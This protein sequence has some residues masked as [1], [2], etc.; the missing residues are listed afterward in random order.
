[1][2]PPQL[3]NAIIYCSILSLLSLGLSLTYSITKVP[4]FAQASFAI[5]G[6][7]TT[8]TLVSLSRIGA[9]KNALLSGANPL[10]I[11]AS[12]YNYSIPLSVYLEFILVSFIIV[13]LVAVAQYLAVL[14]PLKRRGGSP[15][16]L[17]IATIATDMFIF[18]VLNIYVDAAS[19]S[20]LS[21]I[22]TLS[23]QAG[24]KV[25]LSIDARD[26]TYYSYDLMG[27]AGVQR[28][29]FIAPILL[30][31]ILSSLEL[32]LKKTKFGIALRAVV[33]NPN[34]SGVI[35]INVELAS[36]AAWFISGGVSGIA[37]SLIPLKFYTNTS[38]GMTLIISIFA[39]SILGGIGSLYGSVLGAIIIGLSETVLLGYI[40]ALTGIS[41]AYRPIIPLL[42]MTATL[43]L[44]PKGLAGI[45]PFKIKRR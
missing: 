6:A 3:V 33:E 19:S 38:T 45:G 7:Y 5:L 12:V 42:I 32:L 26:F 21:A 17:M 29:L 36:V 22:S 44:F 18:S 4:N 40:T 30:A 43:M 1:M 34:L 14:R 20:F 24:Y 9:V 41:S 28:A 2:L 11:N 27:K 10:E 39:S 13:G 35:G 15:T 23:N 31:A 25:P 8:W 37:G 16:V